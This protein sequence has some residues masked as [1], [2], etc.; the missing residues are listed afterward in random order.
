MQ[1]HV[2]QDTVA[3][4]YEAYGEPN[5]PSHEGTHSNETVILPKG[6]PG[7]ETGHTSLRSYKRTSKQRRGGHVR[8]RIRMEAPDILFCQIDGS[9]L[10]CFTGG[11]ILF[12]N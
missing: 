4:K 7:K 10:P 3:A 1:G 9:P 12:D 8:D 11:G 6:Q 2:P 5:S